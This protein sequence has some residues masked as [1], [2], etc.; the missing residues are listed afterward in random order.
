MSDY[1]IEARL[2]A[3]T[4]D[5]ERGMDRG[6]N[7]VDRG[8]RDM[9]NSLRRASDGMTNIVEGL[10]TLF[11]QLGLAMGAGA[12]AKNVVESVQ[13]F[14]Q[15]EIRLR[16]IMGTAEG[17]EQAFAWI[18]Q[19]A[20][21]TPYSVKTTTDAFMMLKNFGLDPMDGTLRKVADTSAKF[22][23]S[24]DALARISLALGQAWARGKLQ[25]QDIMQMINAGVPVYQLLADATGRSA[26]ELQKMSEKG[27]ITR[28]MMRQLI[29]EMGRSAGGMAE[30][31]MNSLAG[32]VSNMGDSFDNAVD[33]VRRRGG[34]DFLTE[35]VQGVTEILPEL[36]NTF[37]E[38]GAALGAVLGEIWTTVKMV[39]GAIYDTIVWVFGVSSEPMTAMQFF[40]NVLKVVQIA[41]VGFGTGI[42]VVFESIRTTLQWGA[43]WFITFATVANRALKFD[44]SGAGAALEQGMA[45]GAKILSA[46][47]SKLVEIAYA[48]RE[49]IEAILSGTTSSVAV[50][51]PNTKQAPLEPTGPD[52]ADIKA[53][54]KSR[55]EKERLE[56]LYL[57]A[58]RQSNREAQKD[59]EQ[60]MK[61]G[62]KQ[63]Y[64]LLEQKAQ[65]AKNAAMDM[66]ETEE[67]AAQQQYDLGLITQEQLLELQRSFLARKLAIEKEYLEAKLLQVDPE[68]DP[69]AY[70]KV[71][72][73][74]LEV[75]RRYRQQQI[76]LS[77]QAQQE[78]MAPM[79]SLITSFEGLWEQ[80]LTAMLNGTL[81]WSNAFKAI[82]ATLVGWFA[83]DVIGAMLKEWLT[84]EAKK[85]LMKYGF[86][87]QE[88]AADI[89]GAAATVAIKTGEATAVASANAV[90]AGTGAAASQ[91]AIPIVGPALALAAMAAIFAA[92]MGMSKNIKSAAG[93]YDIPSGVNPLIQ[94]HAEEMML[95]AKYANMIRRMADSDSGSGSGD[96]SPIPIYASSDNDTLKVRDL[97]KLLK[98]MGRNFIDMRLG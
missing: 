89:A 50:K 95:P 27:E 88:K 39:F 8:A 86:L 70:A 5:L 78:S 55:K 14:E 32:A 76:Q 47:T 52:D 61:E 58:L 38:V 36:V 37:A 16:G 68:N 46:G 81:R 4:A 13:A 74:I 44:F 63:F 80:G 28:Q 66:V 60:Q 22:G 73:E 26:G 3:D 18:K 49:K 9:E 84:A 71:K 56:K 51:V 19:F 43:N 10:K 59:L 48:G 35:S 31:Q 67:A 62:A 98:S 41:V 65:A 83:R 20:V 6:A 25:G 29:D 85:I 72:E 75:E 57:D 34:F 7:S 23:N 87:A 15:L 45:N 96:Q 40:Q 79:K 77:Y 91:A 11:A 94:G 17:G 24:Q 97:K 21:D 69:V 30:E 93:G 33:S 53:A 92:V 1:D 64:A 82:G 54:E 12:L 42:K 2:G 90:E